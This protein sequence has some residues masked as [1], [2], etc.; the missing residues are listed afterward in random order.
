MTEALKKTRGSC[1]SITINNPTEAD[2]KPIMPPGWELE[3][4]EEVGKEGT[5]HL[6]LMLKCGRTEWFN[7]VKKVF[8]RAHIQKARSEIALAKYVHKEETRVAVYESQGIPSIFEYQKVI[9]NYWDPVVWE[10]RVSAMGKAT[11]LMTLDDCAMGYIDY[12]VSKDIENGQ[13]G[14]EWLAINPM[15]RCSWKKF[16]KNIIAREQKKKL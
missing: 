15:W 7:S 6:Q 8:P 3:G 2:L 16:W 12:L 11:T 5:P 10:N 4:Q 14:A 1:W 13:E 9:A